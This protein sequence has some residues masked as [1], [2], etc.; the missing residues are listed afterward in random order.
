M[1]VYVV[2][3]I[4]WEDAWL[5]AVYKSEEDADAQA[6]RLLADKRDQYDYEVVGMELL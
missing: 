6:E 3:V 2:M 5:N 4:D 1:K